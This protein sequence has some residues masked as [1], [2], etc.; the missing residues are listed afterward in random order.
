MNKTMSLLRIALMILLIL[1]VSGSVSAEDELDSEAA[2][3]FQSAF[4]SHK[5]ALSDQC[6]YSAAA[7][8][9]DGQTQVL[10][11]AEKKNGAWELVIANPDALRRD[12]AV[13]SLLLDTDET[14]FWSY[15]TYGYETYHAVRSNDQWRVVDWMCSEA[16]EDGS[17]SEYH[18]WYG[19]YRL[20]YGTCLCDENENVLSF[21][22]YA[23]VP[24]TW[25]DSQLPLSVYDDAKFPKPNIYYTH[26]WL[27]EEATA[28]AAAEL[29]PGDTFLGG[30]AK[31]EHLEFFL[32]RPDGERII[33]SCRFDEKDGWNIVR[34]TPLPEKTAYGL[35]NFSSSL[36]IGD[37]LINI[38][39][40]DETSCGVTYIYNT[41]EDDGGLYMFSLGKNW[42]TG[43]VPNGYENCFGFH[44]WSDITVMDWNRL[45]RY[46]EEALAGMDTSGWAVVNNPNPAD[47]LHL[48]MKPE[49]SAQSLGKYYNGTPVQILETKG[50]WV[51]VDVFGVAG[52]MMKEY[53]AFGTA[54]HKVEAVFPSRMAVDH[55]KDHF[56]FAKPEA[57]KPIANYL[58]TQQGLLVLGIVGDDWYH[59]WFPEDELSGYV[60]QS[61]WWEGNG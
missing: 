31:R 18:L 37:L 23:P 8:L 19:G 17:L 12:A 27:S 36:V 35:E 54:G 41:A 26:S 21:Y 50:D 59:V 46:L 25:L 53:L 24:A 33:A 15:H 42:I 40:V 52:W 10:C 3:L 38:G 60:L 48:R 11:L 20:Q 39:P 55:K 16:Q 49:R 1:M 30:C 47:R 7:V 58:Y 51:H 5:I 29:F 14:L 9:T 4:P 44:P 2:A 57:G 6:G 34:S 28:L 13:T 22:D 45:P 32:Q 43:E 61:D 56:V